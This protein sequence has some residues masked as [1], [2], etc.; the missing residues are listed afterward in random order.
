[1][2]AEKSLGQLHN[3]GNSISPGHMASIK[4][5]NMRYGLRIHSSSILGADG[6]V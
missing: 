5:G 3:T 2:G 1:M 4:T 6:K